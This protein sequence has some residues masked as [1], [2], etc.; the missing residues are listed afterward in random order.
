MEPV[1]RCHDQE[2][3]ETFVYSDRAVPDQVT[4]RLRGIVGNWREAFC[5]SDAELAAR[6]R[7]DEIDILVELSGHTAQNRLGAVAL[8]PAP[9][10]V[11]YLGYPSTT[12]LTSLDYRFTDAIADP[13]G[14]PVQYSE[15][16]W[17]LSPGFCCYAASEDLPPVSPLPCATRSE[18]TL[19][20]LHHLAKLN[21]QVLDLWASVLKAL[22]ECRLLVFRNTLH[23]F[24]A[25]RLTREMTQRGIESNRF[26][27]R[28]AM[29]TSGSHLSLYDEIDLTLDVLPWSG[30]TTSCESLWMGVPV[31]SLAGNRFAGRMVA[32]V[33]TLAGFTQWIA[34][35]AEQYLEIVRQLVADRTK[36]AALRN[37]L[38]N[39]VA[40]SPLSDGATFTRSL[41]NAY[42]GM[43]HK[44]CAT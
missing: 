37:G 4:Q 44:Y 17:R 36:L 2:H 26:E 23:G 39:R 33:L 19:G 10:Q 41:E 6:I 8:R 16:L 18:I 11:S 14:E 30:H 42:R 20:S 32:S 5:W 7:S 40:H 29:P 43:W 3:F 9:I 15:Q 27:L 31:V 12:G 28:H 38:R 35:D 1:L 24:A 34:T 21:G 22:P 13:P 25:E